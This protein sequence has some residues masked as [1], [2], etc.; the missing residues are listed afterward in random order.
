MI[1]LVRKNCAHLLGGGNTPSFGVAVTNK[2]ALRAGHAKDGM[3][4][5]CSTAAPS[6]GVDGS[7]SESS[8]PRPPTNQLRTD[9]APSYARL[10]NRSA[11]AIHGG[12]ICSWGKGRV[13][14]LLANGLLSLGLRDPTQGSTV[15]AEYSP[16]RPDLPAEK[17]DDTGTTTAEKTR[18]SRIL[19]QRCNR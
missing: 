1:D 17:D 14:R 12:R 13:D 18:E 5:P 15:L 10:A 3:T 4:I 19:I 11:T 2:P 7:G 16:P 8:A 6:H 9:R